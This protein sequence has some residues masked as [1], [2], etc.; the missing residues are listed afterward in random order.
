[1][2]TLYFSISSILC[3]EGAIFQQDDWSRHDEL[4]IVC[5]TND[6]GSLIASYEFYF[7]ILPIM[8]L[9]CDEFYLY[10]SDNPEFNIKRSSLHITIVEILQPEGSIFLLYA[11]AHVTAWLIRTIIEFDKQAAPLLRFFI[12]VNFRYALLF[13][14][15]L[16]IIRPFNLL[17]FLIFISLVLRLRFLILHCT[18]T[19]SLTRINWRL[20]RT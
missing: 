12:L 15:I 16:E 10:L 1:M 6:H 11:D 8:Y 14:F 13:Y 20:G 3:V 19:R 17:Y 9:V 2:I 5:K 7:C 4:L 18:K